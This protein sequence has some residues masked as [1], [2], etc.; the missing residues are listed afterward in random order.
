MHKAESLL[1]NDLNPLDNRRRKWDIGGWTCGAEEINQGGARMG[2]KVTVVAGPARSGKTERLLARYRGALAERA[3]PGRVLWIAPTQRVATQLRDRLLSAELPGCFSPGITNFAGFANSILQASTL[4]IR[5]ISPQLKRQL[6]RRLIDAALDGGK[7]DHFKAIAATDG[8]VDLVAD[9][10]SELKRLEIWPEHLEQAC[11]QRGVS[12]KDRELVQLYTDYQAALMRH[13]LFDQEGRYWTARE[14]LQDGQRRPYEHL[15]LI[16][17]DGFTDL[18]RTQHEMLQLLAE[19]VEQLFV[20]L[21]LE[22]AP[23]RD[24]LFARSTETL[25]KLRTSHPQL[26]VESLAR[27]AGDWPALAHLERD[28]FKS[29]HDLTPVAGVERIEILACSRQIGEV[30]TIGRRIKQLIVEQHVR[31]GEI[32]VVFRSL[33]D[34]AP[35]VRETFTE[36]GLPFAI[37]A[38]QT[39]DQAPIVKALASLL[40]LELDDWPFRQVL[41]L[42][43]NNYF[44]PELPEWNEMPTRT[45]V[46]RLVRELQLPSGRKALLEHCQRWAQLGEPQGDQSEVAWS[47]WVEHRTG[48]AQRALPIVRWLTDAFAQLPRKAT[49]TQWGVALA[50]L[51]QRTGMLRGLDNARDTSEAARMDRIAWERLQK[52]MAAGDRLAEWLG[53]APPELNLDQALKLMLNLLRW[54]SLPR[55]H[56]ESGRVRVMSAPS[57]RRVQISHLFFAGLSERAVPPADREDRLYSEADYSRLIESG[58]P[59][60]DRR[61]RS[62]SEMLLFYEVLTRPTQQLV[63]S[64]P[65]LDEKAQPLSPSS[66]LLEVERACGEGAI[67]RVDD[68]D[69]SPVPR[70]PATPLCPV[71]WRVRAVDALLQGEPQLL[72][73]LLQA[74][75]TP[76][77]GDHCLAA[78]QV[79]HERQRGDSFGPYEGILTSA[80]AKERLAARFGPDYLW[81]PSR[82]E[83]YAGCPYQFFLQRVLRL[84]PVAELALET[85][86][87]KRGQLLHDALSVVHRQLNEHDGRPTSPGEQ[88]DAAF[89]KRFGEVLEQLIAGQQRSGELDAA[90]HEI[91]RR[92]LGQWGEQYQEQHRKYD[93]CWSEMERPLAPAHFEVRF[94]PANRTQQDDE[95]VISTDEPFLFD[96]GDEQLQI[97]GRIDRI[98][99]GQ[100]AGQ[101]VFNVL[102]YK[103]GAAASLRN[104]DIEAGLALQLP[105]YVMAAEQLLLAERGAVPWRTAYWF[106]R[107]T[108][109]SERRALKMYEQGDGRLE[110]STDWLQ[111][112]ET[113]RRKVRGLVDGIRGAEFPMASADEKCTS[114][115]DFRTVC[116]V[117]QTRALKKTWPPQKAAAR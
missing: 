65:A 7:L 16:V 61:M 71:D 93:A 20:T 33:G 25:Q 84:E 17:V 24:D 89:L 68:P 94:G 73:G 88:D 79:T 11:R 101:P 105:L 49:Q 114:R 5:P 113:V 14:L 102:D 26:E 8:L 117:H 82:L 4:E 10:I 103:S 21:P 19:R 46:E 31:P 115:C 57:V 38:S 76:G 2:A 3:E 56:D 41:A 77:L 109:Y 74:E 34:V 69:L 23:L 43:S 42:W 91:D 6:L 45:A 1:D 98:D 67:P 37:E 58:L 97:I 72:A 51:A 36:L 87:M 54:E 108:G 63:L 48:D 75:P 107:E 13:N 64:Y 18:T 52:D 22:E 39:L 47:E 70:K 59:L 85:D 80:A 96:L 66:Y 35:L 83:Q 111:L 92:L 60:V 78:L 110:P 12:A 53:E 112:Q 40:R 44:R 81:S 104:A 15:E 30:Q 29:P 99:V 9:F 27:R 100:M 32:A 95:D 116:R 50:Q 55:A 106:V 90:Q 62:Q 28:L 86:Y